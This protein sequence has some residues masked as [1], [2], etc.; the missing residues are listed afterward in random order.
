[1]K[2]C[3][4]YETF[5]LLSPLNQ[6]PRHNQNPPPLSCYIDANFC[7]T[8]NKQI[9]HCDPSTSQ[10]RSIFIVFFANSP[11]FWQ[12]KLQGIISLSTANSEVVAQSEATQLVKSIN[13]LLY[14]IK[15]RGV[16]LLSISEMCCEVF[17]DSSTSLE[18][19]NVLKYHH[20]RGKLMPYIIIFV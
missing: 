4:R 17:E 12:A 7:G 10:L 9:A 3:Q 14:E 8:W 18:I 11:I 13:Y 2:V 5:R 16:A 19:S 20:A 6:R 1:M 15:T